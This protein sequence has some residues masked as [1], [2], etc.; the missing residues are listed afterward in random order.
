MKKTYTDAGNASIPKFTKTKQQT[1]K[2]S[3][4]EQLQ[5]A[6][7]QIGKS[8]L[9]KDVS[10]GK[11]AKDKGFFTPARIRKYA[12]LLPRVD[13]G[14]T[15]KDYQSSLAQEKAEE[16]VKK[17]QIQ[18]RR[19]ERKEAEEI[20]RLVPRVDFERE[21]AARFVVLHSDS[22]RMA[23]SRAPE[24]VHM[25]GGDPKK[26]DD[27]AAALVTALGEMLHQY[28]GVKKFHVLIQPPKKEE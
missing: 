26:S 7:Y 21:L 12:E 28:A 23:Q 3:V 6:G 25:V 16:E 17:L 8:K 27:L 10:D 20:G 18:N 2:G 5:A 4:L 11:L 22:T 19:E 9:N 1:G 15:D 24:F 13:T 14:Q